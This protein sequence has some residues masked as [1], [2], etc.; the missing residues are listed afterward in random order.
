MKISSNGQA[1]NTS[2]PLNTLNNI[3][4]CPIRSG[5]RE[6]IT[7]KLNKPTIFSGIQPSGSL[8]L[9]NYLGAIS[10]WK[11][12]QAKYFCIFCVV[13]YHAITV[14]QDPK[15]FKDQIIDIAKTYIAGGIDPKKSIIFQQS[16]IKEHTELAWILNC[17]TARMADLNKMTQ[18]KDKS[19]LQLGEPELNKISKLLIEE[20]L[21]A[22]EWQKYKNIKILNE[23]KFV[24][25][26]IKLSEKM[27]KLGYK[28]ASNLFIN[29]YFKKYNK[30]GV[31]LFDYP[32]LMAADILLYNT[33][34]VPVGE[35]QSQHVELTRTL[36]KRFNSQFGNTFKLPQLIIRKEGAR[37]MGLDDPTKKMSKSANS[38]L[39]YIALNDSPA[40]AA[41]KIMRATTDS[42]KNIEYNP[43][44]K[45]GISNL[46]IIYSLLDNK[47]IEALEKKYKNK[48]YGDFKKDLAQITSKF[49]TDFQKKYNKIAD[50]EV[51][52][53]L[54]Q[55]ANKIR[56]IAEETLKT[57]RKK[58][59]II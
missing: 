41:K 51:E 26:M 2:L 52:K 19:G 35:D 17:T 34:A 27:F 38:E 43:K 5:A 8:H 4:M 16:D 57:V 12:L 48:G 31:G 22:K 40:V 44:K 39:N 9:G 46:L 7:M 3:R 11:E 28:T 49:L 56:P 47:P 14:K 54:K 13:D 10:Q 24:E 55:S 58:L 36:A 20:K 25:E 29:E 45:P 1:I 33:D 6:A 59:G 15:K 50:E 23:K 18:F 37:I 53:I 32:A 21:F 30:I 42:G